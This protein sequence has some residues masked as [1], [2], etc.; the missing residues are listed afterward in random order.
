MRKKIFT[1][2]AV[3]LTVFSAS[4]TEDLVLNVSETVS[5]SGWGF[6]NENAPTLTI[7]NWASGGWKFDTP[8]S[9]NDYSGVD[10]TLEA[11]TENHVTLAITYDGDAT[12]NVDV[13]TGSTHIR[14]D[15]V[16]EGDITQIGFSYGDWEGGPAEANITIFKAR[17]VSDGEG[18]VIELPFADI[19]AGEECIKNDEDQSLTLTRYASYPCWVFDPAI[20]SDD[21]EKIVVTFGEP[22]AEEGLEIKAESEDDEWSGSTITGLTKGATKGIAYFSN[23]PGVK[24]K[25]IGFFYSWNNKQGIDDEATLKI[26][27]AQLIKKPGAG[28]SRQMADDVM[29]DDVI[30]NLFGQ[31]VDNPAKGIY[32]KN[33]KKIIIR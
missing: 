33:G 8:L 7:S 24:I 6:S 13:P 28:V 22:I 31:R 3:A 29:A 23:K 21:Y 9:Q 11:T 15:F 2:F 26:A 25:S 5:F 14:A 20:N 27:K 1:F 17:V 30:Y 4:A 32:I 19:V 10:F 16:L 12:Q 18:E